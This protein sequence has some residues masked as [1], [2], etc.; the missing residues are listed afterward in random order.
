MAPSGPPR[1]AREAPDSPMAAPRPPQSEGASSCGQASSGE[2]QGWLNSR[3][4]SVG[5]E[6]VHAIGALPAAEAHSQGY[7]MGMCR[8]PQRRRGVRVGQD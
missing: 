3:Y 4:G 7:C 1:S 5:S 6:A 8:S 2:Q